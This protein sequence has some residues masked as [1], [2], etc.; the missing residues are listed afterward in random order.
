M[1]KKNP[2]CGPTNVRRKK[3]ME[4]EIFTEPKMKKI[5][6]S[7]LENIY[8][9]HQN[10][11]KPDIKDLASSH[12]LVQCSKHASATAQQSSSMSVAASTYDQLPEKDRQSRTHR[13]NRSVINEKRSEISLHVEMNDTVEAFVNQKLV[14]GRKRKDGAGQQSKHFLDALKVLNSNKDLFIKLL[15][16]P[17]S[18]L[19]KHIQ[20]LKE[21]QALQ[22]NAKPVANDEFFEKT[23]YSSKCKGPTSHKM[24]S[25]DRC[26]AKDIVSSQLL[27]EIV[28]LKPNLASLSNLEN[29]AGH[30]KNTRHAHFYFGNIKRKLS[31]AMKATKKKQ[32]RMAIEGKSG[33]SPFDHL[34]CERTN[35]FGQKTTAENSPRKII[36]DIGF[37]KSSLDVKTIYESVQSK[38]SKFGLKADLTC[39][40][41]ENLN[42]RGQNGSNPCAESR[43]PFPMVLGKDNK[44]SFSRKHDIDT[45]RRMLNLA[46]YDLLP[47][48]SP[49]Q[50]WKHQY[51]AAQTSSSACRYCQMV[52]ETNWRLQ[53]SKESKYLAQKKQNVETLSWTDNIKPA[54]QLELC[55]INTKVDPSPCSNKDNANP[56]GKDSYLCGCYSSCSYVYVL[57]NLFFV[58]SMG[59]RKENEFLNHTEGKDCINLPSETNTSG[60]DNASSSESNDT[61]KMLK[62]EVCWHGTEIVSKEEVCSEPYRSSE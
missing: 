21:S 59:S 52:T 28:V 33:Y 24:K 50:D 43:N 49:D 61:A 9:K 18:L 53:K 56:K 62:E 16:D 51:V 35:G 27:D 25:S 12:S 17:N 20:D 1:T 30:M 55:G 60:I 6:A 32:Q 34:S 58:E 11:R 14:D 41:D 54:K 36:S 42:H 44:D 5:T 38:D 29:E 23:N 26:S 10:H 46:E 13:R 19:V 40:N 45:T 48:I 57:V 37:T 22:G 47:K 39:K 31:Q 4:E 15:Q 2:S 8:L 3:P 7:E